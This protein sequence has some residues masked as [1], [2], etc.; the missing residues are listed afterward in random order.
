MT[1]EKLVQ[2]IKELLKT[3]NDLNF[4]LI[5]KEKELERLLACI[6]DRM[7]QVGE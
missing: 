1:K 5:L 6:R 2:K 4:L 7:D 3:D